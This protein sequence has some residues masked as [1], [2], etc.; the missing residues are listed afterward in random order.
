LEPKVRSPEI[1]QVERILF[2]S[3]CTLLNNI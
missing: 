3:E 1:F 2:Y